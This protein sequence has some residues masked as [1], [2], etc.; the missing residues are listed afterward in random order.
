MYVYWY[1][2][3]AFKSFTWT[4]YQSNAVWR[5][6]AVS[7]ACME[8]GEHTCFQRS[9]DGGHYRFVRTSSS[10]VTPY[11]SPSGIIP[12][13]QVSQFFLIA[14]IDKDVLTQNCERT[15]QM[16]WFYLPFCSTSWK[17]HW[18]LGDTTCSGTGRI[19]SPPLFT[20]VSYLFSIL[21]WCPCI[22]TCSLLCSWLL[23][24]SNYLFSRCSLFHDKSRSALI[25]NP[26]SG[27]MSTAPNFCLLLPLISRQ[28][29]T[30][31]LDL[32]L[33]SCSVELPALMTFCTLFISLPHQQWWI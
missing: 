12:M 20:S 8:C 3:L 28:Q 14:N 33:Q 22:T 24:L 16:T 26:I 19:S 7:P 25:A 21:S 2:H 15:L 1:P 4:S 32:F 17:T 11:T 30:P 10:L 27:G 13:C 31:Q 9:W 6:V 23:F 29:V 5:L 18:G